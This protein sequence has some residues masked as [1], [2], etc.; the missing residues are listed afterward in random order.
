LH[1]HI[2]KYYEAFVEG[3]YVYIVMEH[4]DGFNLSDLIKL[5]AEKVENKVFY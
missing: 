1:P 4:I 5:Q 3:E 2:I